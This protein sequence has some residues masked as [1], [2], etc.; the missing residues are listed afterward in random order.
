MRTNILVPLVSVPPMLVALGW[1]AMLGTAAVTG[2]HPIWS[3]EARTVAEAA[4]IGDSAAI[5]RMTTLGGDPNRA[6]EVRAGIIF[7]E[8]TTLTPIEAAA[9]SREAGMVQLLLDLGASLDTNVWQRAW[10][11][12][13]DSDVRALLIPHRPPGTSTVEVCDEP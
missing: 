1:L 4:A 10:C 7:P 9:A 8:N 2:H 5:V 6:G 11:I 12:S 13:D 3:F